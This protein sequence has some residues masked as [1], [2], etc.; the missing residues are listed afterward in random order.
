MMRFSITQKFSLLTIALVVVTTAVVGGLFYHQEKQLLIHQAMED[1]AG[2][3][4]SQGN[5]IRLYIDELQAD[6]ELVS[7]SPPI[8]GLIRAS[9]NG[10]YDPV[11]KSTA[12]QWRGRLQ[13]IF[14]FMLQA[15]H[16]R[17]Y[18]Q[19]RF[20]D[21]QGQEIVR[22]D[23]TAAGRAGIVP[24]SQLQ[25]KADRDYVSE[26]LRLQPGE[27][28]LSAINLN[29]ELGHIVEPHQ[30]MI[31]SAVPVFDNATGRIA[32]LV[33]IN[34]DIG[35][36]FQELQ[37]K[38]A[39]DGKRVFIANEQGDYLLH[40]NA[41][42]TFGFEFGRD[43]KLFHD[44]P[45]TRNFITGNTGAQRLILL[46]EQTVTNNALALGRFTLGSS[47][48]PRELIFC[49]AKPY[50]LVVAGAAK[51]MNMVLLA[52]IGLVILVVALSMYLSYR[53]T[54]PINLISEAASQYARN[55]AITVELPVQGDDEIARLARNFS[56]LIHQ[57]DNSRTALNKINQHLEGL[58][59]QRN[60]EIFRHQ[61]RQEVVVQ[62]IVDGLIT[63]DDRGNVK[64]FNRAAEK[65]F[66]YP[67]E[68]VIGNNIK[69]L[70]PDSYARNHDGYIQAYHDTLMPK[71]IGK[72]REVEGRRR[73]GSQFP[74]ELAINEFWLG[75]ERFYTGI[76]RDITER[77]QIEK[78]KNEFI[79]TVS[80][81][82]RT[83]LTAIKGSVGLLLGNVLGQIPERMREVM[84][85][86]SAN[87]ER[88][89]FLIN[90]LLDIQRIEAGKLVY[91]FDYFHIVPF[92]GQV[93]SMHAA[94][95]EQFGVRFVIGRFEDAE[96]YSDKDRLTQVLGNLMS[97]AAKFSPPG[98][99][100]EV[101]VFRHGDD[102]LRITVSDHG[103]GIA[104]QYQDRIFGRFFQVDGSDAR[105]KGG[106]G[107]GLWISKSI[108]ENLQ[109][110]IGVSSKVG[111]GSTFYVDLPVARP[112]RGAAL[113]H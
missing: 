79:S 96:V 73:D 1:I 99:E 16:P 5:Q 39:R 34:Q 54:R 52:A 72:G 25:N 40:E 71:I 58:I 82:L 53:L 18:T 104:E 56:G 95:G 9:A 60:E 83:P 15:K 101:S 78:L 86:A 106:T 31:R 3:I 12:A 41:A 61:I 55:G 38:I 2:S 102:K 27:K 91:K 94:Y 63:I 14:A 21:P 85:I 20:I 81:E 100:I 57:V 36:V 8:Q 110:A 29:R 109:G 93:L 24:E 62:N 30:I 32:G 4:D 74:M 47:A 28:Y 11:D 10:G 92:I 13:T 37:R 88:L 75:N 98:G 22:V 105:K 107:L 48:V 67:A 80:H 17:H 46:P 23:S 35:V 77:K 68:D 51:T 7:Q 33:V 111:A 45:L 64:D 6:T 49:I 50:H 84:S 97:N 66:G 59:K 19:V 43:L 65:I 42:Q 44:F 26:T 108:M 69:M 113:L 90:D 87:T 89:L 76:V 70:M 112:V 103:P